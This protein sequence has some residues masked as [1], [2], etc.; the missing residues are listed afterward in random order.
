[1]NFIINLLKK[2]IY[3]T[4]ILPKNFIDIHSHILPGIDD[5]AKNIDESNL[6][7][8][9]LKSLGF[10]K[11]IGTPHTYP[12]LYN[13]SV[14]SIKKSFEKIKSKN[15]TKDIKIDYASEYFIG[16]YL[17]DKASKKKLLTIK[18]NYVL[19]EMS[20]ISAP[21]NLHNIIFQLKLNDYVPVIAHPERYR[22]LF[23]DF[24]EYHKMKRLGCKFQINFLSCLGYYGKDV[25]KVTDKLLKSD[26][27]D[28]VGS[29]VH[30]IKHINFIKNNHLKIRNY[31][32]FINAAKNNEI[33]I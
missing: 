12:G 21:I 6:L 19:L 7:I 31:E 4:D 17:I 18:N 30:S 5:G 15:L 26:M 9:E 10:K 11:I 29:D 33:F 3:I 24:N 27:V 28:F 22:F 16:D 23:L 32:N 13:N 20:F 2:K 8:N 14:E 25:L 1:M